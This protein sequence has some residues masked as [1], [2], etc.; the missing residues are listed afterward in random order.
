MA[1]GNRTAMQARVKERVFEAMN[2]LNKARWAL[3]LGCL[4]MASLAA[5]G[6]RKSEQDRP[7]TFEKGNYQG[8]PDQ[9]L[10]NDQLSELRQRA[11]NQ[12]Y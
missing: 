9:K 12:D 1:V 3:L 6:C 8:Q 11:N 7:L 2:G 4:L 10:T 5:G